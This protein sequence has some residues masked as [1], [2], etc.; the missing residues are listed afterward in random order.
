MGGYRRPRGAK[1]LT[2]VVGRHP[3]VKRLLCG[4]VHCAVHERWAGTLAVTVPSIA[5]D[6]RRGVGES[7]F[8]DT[9]MYLVHIVASDGGG[10]SHTRIVTD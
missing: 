7:R 8:K 9:P 10:A 2:A 3:Q 4:H 1:D 5:V 6:V